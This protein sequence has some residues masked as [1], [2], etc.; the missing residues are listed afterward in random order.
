MAKRMGGAGKRGP[1]NGSN[2][3]R[4]AAMQERLRSGAYGTHKQA[5]EVRSAREKQA[6]EDQ[7]DSYDSDGN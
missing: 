2:P 1:R 6:L 3:A 4:V 5:G 7:D